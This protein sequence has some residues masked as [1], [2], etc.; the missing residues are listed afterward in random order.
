MYLERKRLCRYILIAYLLLRVRHLN[1][2]LWVPCNRKRL[3]D[4]ILRLQNFPAMLYIAVTI[5]T[6]RIHIHKHFCMCYFGLVMLCLL[7]LHR[8]KQLLHH[9]F[10]LNFYLVGLVRFSYSDFSSASHEEFSF[11]FST[12]SAAHPRVS[13]DIY[14]FTSHVLLQ[15][16]H[17]TNCITNFTVFV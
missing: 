11:G 8:L 15:H 14:I 5:L 17:T 6:R 10:G 13:A 2:H 1:P 9:I 4:W 7:K 16:L 12:V 3:M